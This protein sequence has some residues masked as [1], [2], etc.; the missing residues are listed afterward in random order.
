M[1]E[2][3]EPR[4]V[5]TGLTSAV[6]SGADGGLARRDE[7]AVN[8][9]LSSGDP[10]IRYLALTE[11]LGRPPDDH[12]VQLARAQLPGGWR[13]Q[14]LLNGQMPDGGFGGNHYRKW[15][16]THWRLVSL[17]ELGMGASDERVAAAAECVLEWQARTVERGSTIIDGRTRIHASIP[18]NALAVSCRL[19]LAN[20]PRAHALAECLVQS[21]WPDGGWNCDARPEAAKSS[22]YE[23]LAPMWGLTEY[24]RATGHLP[25]KT[26]A[27]RTAELLLRHRLYRSSTNGDVIHPDWVRLR[28]PLYWHYDVL[29]ALLMLS[30]IGMIKD[31][32]AADALAIL[33]QRQRADG[34]W[35]P[36]GYY[37]RRPGTSGSGAEEVVDWGRGGPNEMITLNALR[38]LRAAA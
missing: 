33:R 38:V 18:G 35:R 28:Y 36:Q 10:S 9:L 31:A 26:A 5:A 2:W 7:A 4:P 29:Q 12:E 32:R 15:T 34:T 1:P 16:G 14:A 22:F 11:V 24:H 13:V 30:R 37:W 19:G 17:V 23:S 21:Q 20:D 6:H 27:E 25:A 8:W 3:A